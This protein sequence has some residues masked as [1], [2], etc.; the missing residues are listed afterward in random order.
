MIK[1]VHK[2]TG[3]VVGRDKI[4][5]YLNSSEHVDSY[6]FEDGKSIF[7][8]GNYNASN[9]IFENLAFSKKRVEGAFFFYVLSALIPIELYNI[10][11]NQFKKYHKLLENYH[12]ETHQEACNYLWLILFY[13]YSLYSSVSSSL[14]SSA[15]KIYKEVKAYN[16]TREE[17]D[18]LAMLDTKSKKTSLLLK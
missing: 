6:S 16:L 9:K 4:N 15:D 8:Q 17:K 10:T 3:D 14:M 5:L 12:G 7:L 18:M 13:E 11:D 2:G 1:Q